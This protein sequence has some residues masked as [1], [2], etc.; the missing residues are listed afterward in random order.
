LGDSESGIFSELNPDMD[1]EPG[2][3]EYER[4]NGPMDVD[5]PVV[6]IVSP[7]PGTVFQQSDDMTV[8][9]EGTENDS[10]S[11]VTVNF[12]VDGS[13][14]IHATGE[15]V[16]A[17]PIGSDQYEATFLNPAGPDGL[18]DLDARLGGRLKTGHRW[19]SQKRP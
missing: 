16:V 1:S 10:V 4:A 18:R 12:D 7:T 19:T 9:I 13:G 14:A 15:F 11:G 17:T 6:E 8:T 5:P 2:I 3:F